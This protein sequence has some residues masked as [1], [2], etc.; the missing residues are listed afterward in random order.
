RWSRFDGREHR[1]R[2]PESARAGLAK[3]ET[4]VDED[5]REPHL[6]GVLFSIAR[7]VREH[8]YECVLYGLI[9]VVRIAKVA[10]SDAHCAPLMLRDEIAELLPR[11]LSF[12][13][14][15]KCLEPRRERRVP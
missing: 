2:P 13:G 8:F 5:P 9:G 1:N 7:N 6:E 14:Q 10:V 15:H 11:A 3:I 4:P 12:T